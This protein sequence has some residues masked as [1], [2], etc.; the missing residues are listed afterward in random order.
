MAKLCTRCSE[1]KE[2]SEFYLN[3]KKTKHQSHCK[4]CVAEAAKNYRK[5]DKGRKRRKKYY[6]RLEAERKVVDGQKQICRLCNVEKDL[7]EF[8]KDRCKKNGRDSKCKSCDKQYRKQFMDRKKR[9]DKEWNEKNRDTYMIEYRKKNPKYALRPRVKLT[10]EERS[11]QRRKYYRKKYKKDPI[12]RIKCLLR[13]R[14][15]EALKGSKKSMST[16]KLLG[17]T[18]EYAK[19][20]IESQ[21]QKGMSW[22]N[23]GNGPGK[24]NIDHIRPMC[25]FDLSKPEDQKMCCHY[26]NLQPLWWE[27][28]QAKVAEDLKMKC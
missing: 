17:C 3:H 26:T 28:N 20:H 25:S 21:F 8:H 7:N 19:E 23:H 12:Y 11:E 13:S 22:S 2:L 5:T 16:M 15:R 27:D 9:Y 6:D 24:W 18:G 10:K 1:V 14:L 4:A